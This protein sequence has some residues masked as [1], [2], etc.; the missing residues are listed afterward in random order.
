MSEIDYTLRYEK[1]PRPRQVIRLRHVHWLVGVGKAV[2]Q[3]VR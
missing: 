3:K 1:T 2:W